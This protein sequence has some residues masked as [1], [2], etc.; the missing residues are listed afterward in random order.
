MH[1]DYR[2]RKIKSG[3][4]EKI[5][6]E[7]KRGAVSPLLASLKRVPKKDGSLDISTQSKPTAAE[8]MKESPKKGGVSRKGPATHK[9]KK[10]EGTKESRPK[11]GKCKF[12]KS[13]REQQESSRKRSASKEEGG[14][15]EGQ[16]RRRI[17]A[18]RRGK[19][20]RRPLSPWAVQIQPQSREEKRGGGK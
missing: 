6:N 15:G 2:H 4:Q 8:P 16:V 13:E 14:A 11:A 12:E 10:V 5:N 3:S 19:N 1:I 7:A 17:S 9:I 20:T 18:K